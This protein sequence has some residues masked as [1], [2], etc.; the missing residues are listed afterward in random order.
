MPCRPR[1]QH[2]R[3]HTSASGVNILKFGWGKGPSINICQH[4]AR[5]LPPLLCDLSS[6]LSRYGVGMASSWQSLG[7]PR[8]WPGTAGRASHR[9]TTKH[10]RRTAKAGF[11]LLEIEENGAWFFCL[12]P[13]RCPSQSSPRCGPSCGQG[14][15]P[16]ALASDR[17]R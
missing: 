5:A 13:R 8:A 11:T 3:S 1:R 10:R 4:L 9:L 12:E 15:P 2:C 14:A 7:T 17:L 16:T 6:S